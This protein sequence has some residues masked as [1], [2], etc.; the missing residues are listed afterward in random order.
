[1]KQNWKNKQKHNKQNQN[2]IGI[3]GNSCPKKAYLGLSF[4]NIQQVDWVIPCCRNAF[5][6]CSYWY[7]CTTCFG[8]T[9]PWALVF[10]QTSVKGNCQLPSDISVS[11][12]E[13]MYMHKKWQGLWRQEA[14]CCIF[15][16]GWNLILD[17]PI[18][19]KWLYGECT[20]D[21]MQMK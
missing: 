20:T 11:L 10:A 21:L 19:T 7:P 9:V 14:L 18:H 12:L 13:K 1:M 8:S 3:H 15:W 17:F 16:W 2:A 4:R 5:G 6:I